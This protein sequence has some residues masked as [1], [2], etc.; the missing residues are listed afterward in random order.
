MTPMRKEKPR[1]V[2]RTLFHV[3][4]ISDHVSMEQRAYA[5]R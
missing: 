3:E 4:G 2:I 5:S 1:I